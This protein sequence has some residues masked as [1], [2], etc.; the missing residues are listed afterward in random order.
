MLQQKLLRLQKMIAL[1]TTTT[2]TTAIALSST[3]HLLACPAACDVA[4]VPAAL[5][6]SFKI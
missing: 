3:D 5:P 1:L 6:A 2:T 4:P